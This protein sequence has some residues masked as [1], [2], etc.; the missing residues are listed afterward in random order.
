[1]PP[2]PKWGSKEKSKEL[3]DNNKANREALADNP[4]GKTPEEATALRDKVQ[5][6][7]A[8]AARNEQAAMQVARE[9]G[10]MQDLAQASQTRTS[11]YNLL[12]E[13]D[14]Q[15]LR[16]SPTAQAVTIDQA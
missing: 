4:M 11:A 14:R 12:Q 7:I 15:V 5:Q 9:G 16:S 3:Q 10:S 8:D 2:K 13:A 6:N 1:M